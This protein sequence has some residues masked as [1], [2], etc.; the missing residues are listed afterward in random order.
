MIFRL[1]IFFILSVSLAFGTQKKAIF[2]VEYGFLK[3]LG[4]AQASLDSDS[5]T[6]TI[7]IY[8]EA[9]GIAKFLSRNRQEVY[10]STGY[11]QNGQ[12][13]PTRFIQQKNYSDKLEL[14]TYTFDHKIKKVV[15][16]K[17]KFEDNKLISKSVEPLEYY[18]DNDIL[19]LYFNIAE[20]L[21]AI[22]TGEHRI[23]YAV[24]ANPK[25]GKVDVIAPSGDKLSKMK[26]YIG[27]GSDDRHL[28]V[29]INQK[30]F[31][32]DN[33]EL[34]ILFDRAGETKKAV[35][36]DVIFFGDIRGIARLKS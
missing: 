6:Y 30:I 31:Q 28:V 26:S 33:G 18:A 13:V 34:Y 29:I 27:G 14:T 32:S 3:E 10:T 36:K 22:K 23:Y 12:F 5:K 15:K 24:G 7:R 11:I 2:D 21:K 17:E 25:D 8:A 9:S 4:V 1:L 19:T 35:L 16:Q 20:N